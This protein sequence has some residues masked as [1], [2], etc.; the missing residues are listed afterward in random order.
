MTADDAGIAYLLARLAVVE[1]RVRE[2][3]AAR[4]ASD[5]N[6]DDP[7]RG[8]YFSDEMVTRLLDA[9]PGA[10]A[11]PV[12]PA[13]RESAEALA[14]RASGTRLPELTALFGLSPL[15]VE[16]LLIALAG[17]LDAR[18]EALYGYLNDDV[19][20]RRPSVDVA[21]ALCGVPLA[22]A[23]ARARVLHGPL[24]AA[25]LLVVED[26]ERAFAG[27][28]L[29]VPDRVVG[30]LL[31]DD[32]PDP[33]VAA[34][35]RPVPGTA[36]GEAGPLAQALRA[37]TRFGYLREAATASGRALAVRALRETG[38]AAL[39]V[40][41]AAL[42]AHPSAA[43][44]A[45]LVVRD[46]RLRGAGIVAGPVEALGP[47][48]LD[49]L[50][51]TDTPVLLVGDRSWDP[52]WSAEVPLL[53]E[54]PESTVAERAEL[55]LTELA[56]D[57]V[58]R[59]EVEA[60]SQFRLRPEQVVRAAQAAR[61]QARLAGAPAVAVEHLLAGARAENGTALERLARRV[62]PAV[63]WADLVLPEPV[64]T[65]LREITL[66]ARH[67]ERVLGDWRMRPGGGR[68]R[69]VVA[70]FAGDSGTGKTMSAEVVAHDLGLDLYVVD[71]ATVVDK[72]VGE[73]E[74]NLERI[75]A[76]AQGVNAVLLFDEADAVF[77]KRSEV[78]DAHDRY[79]NIESAYLLQ[80]LESF[81]GLAV[82][83][84]NLRANIDD[85]FTRRLDVVVDFPL[86]DVAQRA[87]LW[88]R[89][90]AAALP[91]A[92]GLDLDFCAA[93]FELAG[94]AIRSAAVTAAYLA[95]DDGGTVTMA[96]VVTAVQREYRK[97]GRLTVPSE[98]GDYWSLVR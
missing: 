73:T 66:R 46:A 95:A 7:F 31:G 11:G 56:E 87:R 88:D 60:T 57:G 71:L 59:A 34:V 80:R 40:D 75:F 12:D 86:P 26:P 30:H 41:L 27:R 3:V 93:A 14:E 15:D 55:W 69:G 65:G 83:A 90:L 58:G 2:L 22:S 53:L 44:L 16:L 23:A 72:Y 39:H 77:G 20:R 89:C 37:G 18:F 25:R 38:R 24:V 9:P 4:R 62:R 54:V 43:D 61:V 67:R 17:D 85:A 52:A 5:P 6:P 98:F 8:L 48:V 35:L 1:Q 21:F 96:H 29:R 19:T 64:L 81:D 47:G 84:T 79:A 33:A 97:L 49:A 82:L 74:K 91:R 51:A 36:W 32:T 78:K 70:L 92:D 50:T 63:G 76:A 28:S 94:G 68:G 10:V 13:A 42:A 45:R